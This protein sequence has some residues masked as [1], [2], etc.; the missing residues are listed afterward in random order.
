MDIAEKILRA[1]TDYD[2]VYDKGEIHGYEVGQQEEYDKFWNAFQRNGLRTQYSYAYA[3]MMLDNHMLTLKYT[4]KPETADYMFYMARA[5]S[6]LTLKADKFDFSGC[7]SMRYAFADRNSISTFELVDL[8]GCTDSSSLNYAFYDGYGGRI[9]EAINIKS[10]EKTYYSSNTFGYCSE[11]VNLSIDGTIGKTINLS[12]CTKLSL[13]SA[14]NVL[15]ALKDFTG[16]SEF[17]CSISLSGETWAKLDADGDTS[18]NGNT[19][20]DYV[21]DKKWS[22]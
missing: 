5:S 14:K 3:D 22:V 11:L 6:P 4:V 18:P 8:T 9:K 1:K 15:T 20:R 13:E 16:L 2:E 17:S 7:K 10:N 21:D 19:W 12:A